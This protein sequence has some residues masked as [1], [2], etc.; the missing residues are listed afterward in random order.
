M[1]IFFWPLKKRKSAFWRK[2]HITVEY[3][4]FT[5]RDYKWHT[6]NVLVTAQSMRKTLSTI[7]NQTITPIITS[8]VLKS[9]RPDWAGLQNLMQIGSHMPM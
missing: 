8:S 3:T 7:E 4:G 2:F 9:G 5:Q 6:G 1:G